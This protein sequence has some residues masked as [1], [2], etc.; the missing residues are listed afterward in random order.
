[1]IFGKMICGGDKMKF[2]G[3]YH[4][5]SRY[6]DGR[7]SVRDIAEAAQKKGMKEVAV[8]DHG[9]HAAVIGVKNK[10]TYLTVKEEVKAIN[11]DPDFDVTVFTGAEAN[12]K[13]LQGDLDV[14]REII[15]QLDVLIAGLHPYTK[16]S[17]WEDGLGIWVQ[18]SLRHLGKDQREK[19][20]NNNTKATAEALYRHPEID[21]LAH[22]GLFFSVDMEETARACIKNDVLFEINC[23]HEHPDLSDI[24]KVDKLGVDFIVNSDAH[25][26]DTVARLVYGENII[27]R[28]EI[29]PYRIA[30]CWEEREDNDTTSKHRSTF[31]HHY[32]YVR[33]RQDTDYKL[34]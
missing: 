31:A 18:N 16:P 25:F 1:M 10:K 3:D 30:N 15:A 7:Q 2:Y 22:P 12:I 21:I 26:T 8:T 4:T 6:S 27:S 20:K 17:S 14:P 19:A 23:G 9:P 29:E 11:T 28:L 24:I 13:S 32:R 34:P 33:R 5:H